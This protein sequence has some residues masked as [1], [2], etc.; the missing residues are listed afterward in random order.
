MIGQLYA[1]SALPLVAGQA[2]MGLVTIGIVLVTERGRLFAVG[3]AD[4]DA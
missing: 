1:D 4:S 3:E 2:V